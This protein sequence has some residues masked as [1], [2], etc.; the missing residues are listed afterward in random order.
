MNPH[1]IR[2]GVRVDEGAD[3]ENQ[4]GESLREF[5]SHSRRHRKALTA[6]IR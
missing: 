4:K 1:F 3:L 5:E 6:M 2:R